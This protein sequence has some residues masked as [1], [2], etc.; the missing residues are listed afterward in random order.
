ADRI[1][2]ETPRA[3][4]L[5]RQI[6]VCRQGMLTGDRPDVA[7]SVGAML[8]VTDV[9]AEQ[10]PADKLTAIREARAAG[11]VIMVGDGV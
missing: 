5:L 7:E 4:R 6:G 2:L 11:T 10:S 3:L 9:Y 1:R 8:G